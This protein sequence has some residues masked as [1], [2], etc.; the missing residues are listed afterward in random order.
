MLFA[1]ER[2]K[3]LLEDKHSQ[4]TRSRA[5]RAEQSEGVGIMEAPRGTL[6][7]HYKVDEDG[8][9]TSANLIIATGHNNLAMNRGVLQVARHFVE[10]E[11]MQ[12]AC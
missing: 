12:K 3:R 7:H 2:M 8:L 6:I 1:V 4:Q 10:G 5:C 9:I 11:K